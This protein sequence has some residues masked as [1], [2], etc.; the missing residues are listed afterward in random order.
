M[1]ARDRAIRI[2]VNLRVVVCMQIDEARRND[3]PRCID[4]FFR[5]RDVDSSHLGDLAVFNSDVACDSRQASAVYDR[6]IL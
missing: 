6:A 2:P 3:K 5:V 4:H 1:P